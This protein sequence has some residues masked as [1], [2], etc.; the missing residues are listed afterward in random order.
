MVSSIVIKVGVK[1][2]GLV[3][4]ISSGRGEMALLIIYF[5]LCRIRHVINLMAL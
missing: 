2:R 3:S 1:A 5:N 4:S